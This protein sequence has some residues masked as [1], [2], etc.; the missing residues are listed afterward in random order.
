MDFFVSGEHS[1]EPLRIKEEEG[2]YPPLQPWR[3]A[4]T[5]ATEKL[6]CR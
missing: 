4:G 6:L 2:M 5:T 3:V 1:K